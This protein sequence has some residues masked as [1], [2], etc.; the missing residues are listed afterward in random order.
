MC[1]RRRMAALVTSAALLAAAVLVYGLA[2]AARRWYLDRR[3]SVDLA[4]YERAR[5]VTSG[6]QPGVPHQ[7]SAVTPVRS[8]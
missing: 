6:P 5:A 3:F 7:R 8:R 2:L 1:H 4:S